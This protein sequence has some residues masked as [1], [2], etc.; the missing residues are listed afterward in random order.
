MGKSIFE[1][2][3]KLGFDNSP[4]EN[5]WINENILSHQNG[6]NKSIF[7]I[8]DSWV[9]QGNR[10]FSNGRTL[11][12]NKSNELGYDARYGDTPSEEVMISHG[13]TNYDINII[14]FTNVQP[15]AY[16]EKV[17]LTILW[18]FSDA[19]NLGRNGIN[20]ANHF[21]SGQGEDYV[22]SNISNPSIEI[23]DSDEF[24]TFIRDL[25][26]E[27]LNKFWNYGYINRRNEPYNF[28]TTLPYFNSYKAIDP[29]KN[30]A[31]TFIG[32]IQSAKVFYKILRIERI[33]KIEI[34]R[35]IFYDN[36]GADWDDGGANDKK[37]FI[38]GLVELFCLQHF[39]NAKKQSN[40]RPFTIAIDIDLSNSTINN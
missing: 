26:I 12:L 25:E 13:L 38:P 23:K 16:L 11:L 34:H 6:N 28:R 39:S 2:A 1:L 33:L 7:V 37:Q 18:G 8:E 4:W 20:L 31:S 3:E 24:K 36:F 14:K 17:I 5:D 21:I 29:R 22:F 15:D 40:Y 10:K 32:G 19:R 9:N 27:L 30:E 35:V